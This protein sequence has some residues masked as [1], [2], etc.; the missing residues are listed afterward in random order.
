MNQATLNAAKRRSMRPPRDPGG[1]AYDPRNG[2]TSDPHRHAPGF[3]E[4]GIIKKQKIGR[5]GAHR[6]GKYN[7]WDTSRK[8]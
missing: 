5:G 1:G 8:A 7:Y 6:I 4:G 2:A 3:S